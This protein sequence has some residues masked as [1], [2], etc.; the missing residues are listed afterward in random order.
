LPAT[1][2]GTP[3]G[4][5]LVERDTNDEHKGM[6]ATM[7]V[8]AW[9][10]FGALLAFLFSD[11]LGRQNN[12]NRSVETVHRGNGIREVTL[13]RN[14]YG[15]YVTGGFINGEPVVFLLDTGATGVAVPES[16][17]R[18]LRLTRGRAFR[19]QTANGLATA[20]STRLQSV[21]VGEI[22]L[23]DVGAGISP[24]LDTREVLLGMSFLRH[25]EFTQRGNTLILRQLPALY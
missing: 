17:A 9:L 8:L 25:I 16:V 24:G 23:N 6:G 5:A 10:V 22:E 2:S 3:K 1:S 12:P 15:H 7:Y 19:T 13:R 4:C 18:R 11:I 21:R 14:R 20:Y